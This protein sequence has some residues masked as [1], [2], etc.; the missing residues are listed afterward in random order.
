MEARKSAPGQPWSDGETMHLI[1]VYEDRWTKLR[2]GQL[3]AHQWEDVAG[4]VTRRCGGQ[5][6]TGTQC[7][8]K[9]EKLRKRYRTEAARPVTSLWPFFRRMERLERG[10]VPV[11]TNSF[12]ASPPAS[13]DDQDQDL[14]P[15]EE[16]EDEEE[17]EEEDEE[18]EEDQEE[19]EEQ[20]LVARNTG[21]HTR[22]INGLV[23]DAGGFRG[24]QQQQQQQRRPSP[25][26]VTLSTAPPRKRVSYEAAMFQSKAAA[27]DRAIK[28]EEAPAVDHGSVAGVLRD[29]GEGIKRLE[30]RRMEVQWEIEQGWKETEAR[31]NQMLQ[32]AQRQLQ[33]T[34]AALPPPGKKARRDHGSSADG[35]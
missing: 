6:K 28:A 23:R 26:A 2:R 18:Q 22:S 30:R 33:D 10:P 35:L 29:I 20:L 15:E 8:H 11:S 12:P 13:D 16:E 1:D 19:E 21:S 14:D 25:P 34:L 31:S 4:E 32:D 5:R 7:R 3:K 17:Q 9:L 24:H 27:A